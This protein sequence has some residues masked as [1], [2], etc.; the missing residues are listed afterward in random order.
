MKARHY[1]FTLTAVRVPYSPLKASLEPS[2]L[3]ATVGCLL[4]LGRVQL[5]AWGSP[6]VHRPRTYP[7]SMPVSMPVC[8][9]AP[10]QE[11]YRVRVEAVGSVLEIERGMCSY[12]YRSAGRVRY[13]GV[14]KIQYFTQ[15][16]RL[17]H[18][19]SCRGLVLLHKTR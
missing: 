14:G 18:P 19:G 11:V 15:A 6:K 10:S 13:I 9:A 4:V 1:R 12:W 3:L 2:P 17:T 7:V 5:L 16:L 8:V